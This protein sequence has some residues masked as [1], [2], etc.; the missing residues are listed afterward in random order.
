VQSSLNQV[1]GLRLPVNGVMSVATRNALRTFQQQHGLPVDGIAGPETERA[2]VEARAQLRTQ[3]GQDEMLDELF[4]S[5]DDRGGEFFLG[6]IRRA[7]SR[8]AEGVRQTVARGAGAVSGTV[9]RGA[10]AVSGVARTL[11]PAASLARRFIAVD[12]LTRAAVATGVAALRGENLVRAARRAAQAGI[13]D[14][15]EQLRYAQMVAPFVPGVGTG[16][17]AALGAANALAAGRPITEAVIAAAR[18]AL[19]G[20]AIAQM[21][22]DMA[23]N[24]ARGRS[25]S[26]AAL[27]AARAR[28]PGGAAA[29][30]A[31]DSAVALS[32]GKRIQDA[33]YA[34]AGRALPSS[35]Y[36]ADALSFVR[37][38]A[39]GRNI[40][41][42]A[43]SPSGKRVLGLMQ[44]QR[45]PASS[46]RRVARSRRP[47]LRRP[48]VRLSELDSEVGRR[49]PEYARWVQRSLNQVLGLRLVED[50]RIGARTRSAIRSF[51]QRRGLPVDGIVGGRTERALVAA[52]ASPPPRAS[53]AQPRVTSA[54]GRPSWIEWA[55]SPYHSSRRGH[56]VTAIIYHFTAGPALDGTVRYFTN[57][58]RSVSAH[59]V[60]GKDGRTVQMVPLERAAHHAGASSLAGCRGG[61]NRCSV[62]I[63]IVNWGMLKKRGAAFYTHSGR[64][65]R[66]PSPVSARG[67]YWEPFTD[68]QYDSLIRLTRYLLSGN[69]GVTHIVGHEDI[70]PGRKNDPG[71]AFDWA[72]VRAA[73]GPAFA[74]HIGP[75]AAVRRETREGELPV[76]PETQA[77]HSYFEVEAKEER[78]F[79]PEGPQ[80]VIDRR[81]W[82]DDPALGRSRETP[83]DTAFA[84]G[85]ASPSSGR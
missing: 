52:G 20:G 68:A 65:Y 41:T 15:R 45:R 28:L 29:R 64:P 5:N 31:F 26:Q 30:A 27:E 56:P 77:P 46:S 14:L 10:S 82:R 32:R 84:I 62:G 58:D 34:A 54:P 40:Q 38:V 1:L 9:A 13:R 35:P 75:L 51:Q 19:P 63:E 59:Y 4:P 8:A 33:A 17:A 2:L 16:V 80:G 44:R 22:F 76:E 21:G 81:N 3:S 25:V 23:L 67:R 85:R 83:R 55:P 48:V 24:L 7:V 18:N 37:S 69:P 57:N 74:G 71:G 12:P 78:Q 72:R 73:I 36:A 70:A 42:A 49:S 43:L 50:G 79:G 53:S 66:G 11:A 47:R 61:V 60:I 6:G 39:A